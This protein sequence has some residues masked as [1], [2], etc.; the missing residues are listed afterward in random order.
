M[1]AQAAFDEVANFLGLVSTVQPLGG[2]QS[3][4][5][6]AE[7]TG[8]HGQQ[9]KRYPHNKKNAQGAGSISAAVVPSE[10]IKCAFEL[11]K[12][13]LRRDL[14]MT[15]QITSMDQLYGG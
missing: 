8:Q 1:A 12:R 2:Q 9:N 5:S 3:I 14:T 10:R 6:C 13:A 11:A 4:L 7:A 15:Q